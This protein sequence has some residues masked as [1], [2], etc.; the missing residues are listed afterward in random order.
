MG[1]SAVDP[2]WLLEFDA[3]MKR[4][5]G[6]GPDDLGVDDERLARLGDLP[7]REAAAY[8]GDKYD[9]IRVDG[10]WRPRIR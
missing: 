8:F 7:P 9:L 6:V 3:E 4:L 5:F 10:Y 1:V 2:D